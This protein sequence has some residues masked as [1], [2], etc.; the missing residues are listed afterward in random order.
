MAVGT[1]RA[2]APAE[3]TGNLPLQHFPGVAEF[4]I[5]A[6]NRGGFVTGL[7]H[8]VFAARITAIA[9]LLPGRVVD[10]IAESLVMLVGHQVA[11]TF[12]AT[13]IVSGI[14]PGSAHHVALAAEEFH[15]NG[16]GDDVE[17]FEEL[18]GAAEFFVDVSAG[19]E[20][21]LRLHRGVRVRRR[22]HVAIDAERA[23]VSEEFGDF[24][25]VGFLINRGVGADEEARS[26]GGLDAG[27]G[28]AEDAVALDAEI[29]SLLEAV[30]VDVEEKA[31]SG[32]Q[33]GEALFDEH[34]VGAKVDVPLARKNLLHQAANFGI[35]ERFAAADGDDGRA[36]VFQ[37]RDALL[38][39]EHL[40]DRGFVFADAAAAR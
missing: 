21:V 18:A 4:A 35:D 20:Y 28:F 33:L 40:V 15:V 11:R 27:D 16:R 1:L 7:H 39:R 12:P 24:L 14:A 29:V 38:N 34:A 32:L 26:L 30:Q 22:E 5:A 2:L 13:R 6:E 36:A 25:D 8:A 23:Q 19:H 10:E 37:S 3:A 31:R 17:L 9:V